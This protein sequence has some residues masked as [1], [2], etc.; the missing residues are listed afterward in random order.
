M[1]V[2]ARI[3][4]VALGL[5]AV[6]QLNGLGCAPQ[7]PEEQVSAAIADLGRRFKA[8]D[9]VGV[10]G[11]LT[12][13]ARAR[14]TG[15]TEVGEC[16]RALGHLLAPHARSASIQRSGRRR[17]MAVEVK[18][19]TAK[20]IVTL[21][22]RMPGSLRLVRR[23]GGWKLDDLRV[24]PLPR[25]STW[26]E[27]RQI[28]NLS[29]LRRRG[30]R[31][32]R[33]P[34]ITMVTQTGAGGVRG[35]CSFGVTSDDASF[36]MLTALGDFDETNVIVHEV[37]FSG[38][39]PCDRI[40]HCQD[41]ETGLRY[42]WQGNGI[43]TRRPGVVLQI[44]ICVNTPFGRVRGLQI[45]ELRRLHRNWTALSV[46]YPVGDRSMQIGGR[47]DVRPDDLAFGPPPAWP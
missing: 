24:R 10:C 23:G 3:R 31:R 11:E 27:T 1:S 12:S 35:G 32:E 41:G 14:A 19:A 2:K 6:A 22:G 38:P 17:V 36:L 25:R 9:L 18:G 43:P 34:A 33:C 20:A 5:L 8:G 26:K 28:A 7:S 37:E 39:P 4:V 42:P 45:T 40:G 13:R 44:D 16:S 47:W 21:N 30:A 29:P 46:D 15:S